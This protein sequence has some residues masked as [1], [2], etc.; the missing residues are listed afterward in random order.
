MTMAFDSSA[1]VIEVSEEAVNGAIYMMKVLD[2]SVGKYW[3]LHMYVRLYNVVMTHLKEKYHHLEILL[4]S[5]P[6]ITHHTGSTC[7]T[8]PQ[9]VL[10]CTE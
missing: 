7:Y 6:T 9:M 3:E 4:P 1:M 8:H 2:S 5:Q 10:D